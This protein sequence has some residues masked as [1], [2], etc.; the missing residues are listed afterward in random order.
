MRVM[1]MR[2]SAEL[3]I[4][5]LVPRK[6]HSSVKHRPGGAMDR[7]ACG[8]DPEMLNDAYTISADKWG[9]GIMLCRWTRHACRAILVRE[10]L[11]PGIPGL[12][13]R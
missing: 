10:I 5:A 12:E 4:A 9:D 11:F 13:S 6:Y 7:P 1:M 8:R 2:H 3:A